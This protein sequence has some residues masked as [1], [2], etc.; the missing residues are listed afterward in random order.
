MVTNFNPDYVLGGLQEG[1]KSQTE[2]VRMLEELQIMIE[3][4]IRN[5]AGDDFYF[6]SREVQE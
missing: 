5:P 2:H 1:L 6:V 4:M 3:K